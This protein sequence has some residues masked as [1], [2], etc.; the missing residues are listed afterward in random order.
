MYNVKSD[1]ICILSFGCIVGFGNGYFYCSYEW[2]N[3]TSWQRI[4]LPVHV[5]VWVRMFSCFCTAFNQ[6]S[7]RIILSLPYIADI[8]ECF[9]IAL[10]FLILLS[11]RLFLFYGCD[12][13]V[14]TNRSGTMSFRGSSIQISV[15]QQQLNQLLCIQQ[16]SQRSHI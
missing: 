14:R 15:T 13:H 8:V 5:F 11:R 4:A 9:A 7:H 3:V 2:I 10:S 1:Q 12:I 16:Q 6:L